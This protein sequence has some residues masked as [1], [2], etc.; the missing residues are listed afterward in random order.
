MNATNYL[1][2]SKTIKVYLLSIDKDDQ[3]I[4]NSPIDATKQTWLRDMHSYFCKLEI[5]LTVK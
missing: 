3:L 2:Q 4:Q 5:Q 1:E